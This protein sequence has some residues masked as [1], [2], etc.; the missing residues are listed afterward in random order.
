MEICTVPMRQPRKN[1]TRRSSSSHGRGG[2]RRRGLKPKHVHTFVE[3]LFGADMHAKRVLSL[4]NAVVG[5]M[6]AASLCIHAIGVGLAL[7]QGLNPKHAIKQVDRLLS[8]GKLVVWDLFAWWVPY[9]VG[10]RQ[11]IV[12][13]IDWTEFEPD[14]QS[15]IAVHLVTRHGRSTPLVWKTEHKAIITDGER[16]DLEDEVLLRLRETLPKQVQRVTVLADRGF[17]D[18]KL[19]E[20]FTEEFG[21][22]FI[23]RFRGCI[24][25]TDAHGT[26]KPA[27]QWLSSLGRARR[28]RNVTVTHKHHPLPAVVVVHDKKMKEAWCLATTRSDLTAS[29]VVQLYG[30]RFS[31]EESFRDS[32]D[33]H[34]GMGLSWTHISDPLRRDRILFVAALAQV[35]LT[36]LGAASE[37]TGLDRRLKANTVQRRTHSLLRQGLFWY[38]AIPTMPEDSLKTLMEAFQC[39]VTEQALVRETFG[40]I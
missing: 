30:R 19:Y 12:V 28:L 6:H 15:T 7:A 38:A 25:V 11:S 40:L 17:G 13:A 34:F 5:V 1:K 4:S 35:L 27:H 14:G 16:N 23:I 32:K 21:W 36:M 9:V 26:S 37:A 3:R 20:A 2:K 10:P 39:I 31:I 8:N 29:Q 33:I 24:T 18:I 22:D